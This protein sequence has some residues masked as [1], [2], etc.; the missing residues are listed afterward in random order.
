MSY[1]FISHD[2]RVIKSVSH[3]VLIMKNG[4]VV[5]EGITEKI[6]NSPEKEYTKQLIKAAFEFY[7]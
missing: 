5:E 6:F 4:K 3:Y 1:I 2:L 7:I